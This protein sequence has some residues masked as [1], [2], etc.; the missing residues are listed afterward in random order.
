MLLYEPL[1]DDTLPRVLPQVGVH[2]SLRQIAAT[3]P[4]GKG[5]QDHNAHIDNPRPH[6][7]LASAQ[8]SHDA[9]TATMTPHG[10]VITFQQFASCDAAVSL[11]EE[12]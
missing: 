2:L 4:A 9:R 11:K 7:C 3:S 1:W 5:L 8:I 6:A 10:W 12:L